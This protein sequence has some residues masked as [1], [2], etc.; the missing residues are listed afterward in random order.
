MM[1]NFFF[2]LFLFLPFVTNAQFTMSGHVYDKSDGESLPGAAI[3]IPKTGS[4]AASN[5]FG[6][7][8]ITVKESIVRLRVSYLGYQEIDTTIKLS[9]NLILDFHLKEAVDQLQEIEVSAT[10]L[11]LQEQINSTRM[12]TITLQPSE[13]S[14]IPTIGGETDLIKVAQLLPGVTSGSEGTTGMFVRGGTVLQ[15]G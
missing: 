8:S 10:P 3:F 15:K 4:G 5:N 11:E 14:M 2:I 12:G 9:Q 7:Y 1:R 6:F 13:I